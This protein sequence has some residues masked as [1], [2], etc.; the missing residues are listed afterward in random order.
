M[1][2]SVAHDHMSSGRHVPV[3][4]LS[5]PLFR[6]PAELRIAIF[7][8]LDFPPI[9]NEQ[10][11]GLILSCRQA[12]FE[13]EQVA[14]R[15]LTLWIARF[16]RGVVTQCEFKVRV[17]LPPAPLV[18]YNYGF[19]TFKELLVILLCTSCQLAM[20]L[21]SFYVNLRHLNPVFG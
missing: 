20:S 3:P 8:C 17:F 4:Q 15:S 14:V 5:S 21:T 2:A 1:Q 7:E 12:Q 18:E 9:S 6:L 19:R 13:C 16:V 10:C 11:H